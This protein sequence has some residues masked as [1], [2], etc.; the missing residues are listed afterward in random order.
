[1]RNQPI[2]R[3]DVYAAHT[4]ARET[5]L[6]AQKTRWRAVQTWQQSRLTRLA[7][8]MPG[9]NRLTLALTAVILAQRGLLI[10][11]SSPFTDP[12]PAPPG[13]GLSARSSTRLPRASGGAD[14][15]SP[16]A[17]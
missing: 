4:R 17:P 13:S 10:G 3:E 12:G 1:M 9:S 5:M 15:R 16:A 7:R 8:S 14:P 11:A 2:R 6:R